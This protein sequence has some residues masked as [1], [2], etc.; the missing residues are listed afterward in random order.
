MFYVR[1]YRREMTVA[2]LKM[3]YDVY[4]DLLAKTQKGIDFYKKLESSV[5]SLLDRTLRVC[6]V[7]NEERQQITAR[8]KPKG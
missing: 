7:Q 4:E 6:K 2:D 1:I 5:K 8:L 3:S